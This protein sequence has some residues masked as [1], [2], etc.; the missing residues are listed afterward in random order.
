[1]FAS[2]NIDKIER[3]FARN[4]RLMNDQNKSEFL[5]SVRVNAHIRIKD[6]GILCSNKRA[7]VGLSV[8][9]KNC[10]HPFFF[11]VIVELKF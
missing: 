8:A 11:V 2:E 9:I 4:R 7:L 3:A 10:L 5:L 1:M 6:V